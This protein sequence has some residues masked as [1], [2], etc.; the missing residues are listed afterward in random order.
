MLC[1]VC[2]PRPSKSSKC[3][4]KWDDID[5][6]SHFDLGLSCSRSFRKSMVL[7]AGFPSWDGR[8]AVLVGHV[9]P[10]GLRPQGSQGWCDDVSGFLPTL[11]CDDPSTKSWILSKWAKVFGNH[12]SANGEILWMSWSSHDSSILTLRL[13]LKLSMNNE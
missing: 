3:V 5:D 9:H 1:R 2:T 12:W 8:P 4:N 6:E 11:R 10:P 13:H 7:S